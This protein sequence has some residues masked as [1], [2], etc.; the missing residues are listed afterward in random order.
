M[1]V[2]VVFETHSTTEDNEAGFATGWRPGRLSSEG[3]GQARLLGARRRDDR[4][5]VVIT[6]DLERALE[7]V[8]IAFEGW[9]GDV[10]HDW[11]LRECDYGEDTLMTSERLIRERT[12]HL[13]VPY[14]GGESWREAIERVAGVLVDV[15]RRWSG[16]RVLVIG[17]TATRFALDH[18]VDGEPL[19][20]L[21]GSDFQWRPG[22]EYTL[23]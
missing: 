20:G 21:L 3:R 15:R 11:R 12:G 22:W 8:R 4:I 18:V 9:P 5:D 19:E 23:H 2:S 1:S 16:G 14:P 7:T 17:H 10:L 13:D 6:S